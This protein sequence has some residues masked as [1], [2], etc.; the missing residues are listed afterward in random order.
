MTVVQAADV[1]ID[2]ETLIELAAKL[3]ATPLHTDADGPSI[4]QLSSKV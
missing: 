1:L 2:A 3:A 4:A